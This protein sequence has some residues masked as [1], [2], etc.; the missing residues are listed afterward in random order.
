M[1]EAAGCAE[2]GEEAEQQ[3]R[4]HEVCYLGGTEGAQGQPTGPGARR[5]SH[6]LPSHP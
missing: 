2:M 4:D 6:W 1:S 5:V 3:A